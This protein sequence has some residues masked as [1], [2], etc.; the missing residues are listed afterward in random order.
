MA[1]DDAICA[2]CEMLQQAAL[3]ATIR[4]IRAESSL[5]IAIMAHDSRKIGHLE[6]LVER[7]F[8]ERNAAVRAYQEHVDVHGQ[9]AQAWWR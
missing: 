8:Q 7:L 9:T 6:P 2:D 1:M 3:E 4:H 5:A